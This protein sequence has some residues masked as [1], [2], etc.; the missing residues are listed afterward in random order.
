MRIAK[1][2]VAIQMIQRIGTLSR[3]LLP[4]MDRLSASAA[5]AARTSHNLDEI[6]GY[7]LPAHGLD[8]SA[9]ISESADDSTAYRD[10]L[11]FKCGFLP[12][13]HTAD[14]RKCIRICIFTGHK[15]I[16]TAQG[17]FHDTAG[18]S[19]NHTGSTGRSKRVIQWMILQIADIDMLGMD[20]TDYLTGCQNDIH[21]TVT[22]IIHDRNINFMLL[23]DTW[24]DRNIVNARWINTKLFRKPCFRNSTKHLMR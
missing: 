23:C 4:V 17:S 13:I 15:I 9:G 18:S 10:S 12:A 20:H 11:Y 5:A 19:E 3:K 14:I 1:L 2:G 7:F 16:G 21:I 24:H 8:E 22:G 6:I